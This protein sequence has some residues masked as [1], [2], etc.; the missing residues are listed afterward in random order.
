[1]KPSDFLRTILPTDG[2]YALVGIK[3]KK[4]QQVLVD[5]ITA[6]GPIIRASL[7]N[8]EDVYFGCASYVNPDS[9]KKSN[10]YYVKSFWI[11]LDCGEGTAYATQQD[12]FD[13]LRALCKSASMPK[14][15]VVNSGRGLHVYWP[16]ETAI[17]APLWGTYATRLVEMC[18]AH[19][20]AIKDPGCSTDAARILR[21]PDTF[22]FKNPDDPLAV[23][24]IC[25]GAV[26]SWDSLSQMI[27]AACGTV[28]INGFH[29][30]P[31]TPAKRRPVDAVTAALMG[32]SVSS[33]KKIAMRS[34]NGTGCAHIA[35]A[36]KDQAGTPEP[37]WRAGL[38]IAEHCEDRDHAI[39]KISKE[40]PEYNYAET[41]AKAAATEGPYKCATIALQCGTGHCMKCE[42]RNKITSPIQLGKSILRA[43]DPIEVISGDGTAS[44]G[45]AV[46]GL[47]EASILPVLPW[48]Y[49]RGKQGGIYAEGVKG[50][51][52]EPGDDVLIYE[53]NLDI[54]RRI[55]D[56]ERGETLVMHLALPKD[57]VQELVIPLADAQSIERMK[58]KLG[59]HGVAA[60]KDQ[61]NRISTYMTKM[62]KHMQSTSAAEP[63][64]TQMGWTGDRDGIVWGR[65]MFTKTGSQYCPPAAKSTTVANM[66]RSSGSLEMWE[67]IA[68][69]YAAPGFELYACCMVMAFG[70]MLNQYT[71]E[72]PVWIH[73]VSSDSGT[74][75]TTL[76]HVMDSIWGDPTTMALTAAD[77]INSVEKRRVVFNSMPIC[78]DEITNYPPEKISQ[79]AYSQSQGREKLRLTSGSQEMVNNDRRNNTYFSTGN[80]FVSDI[81][82]AFKTNSAGE[83]ARLIEI[84]FAPLVELVS[85]DDHFGK[86]K[87][88]YGHA[89]PMFAKW[90]VAHADEL[91]ERVDAVRQKF[92]KDFS[93]VSK[94]RN[95]VGTTAAGFAAITIL[96]QELGLLKAYDIPRLYEF[97]TSHMKTVRA[98][99][100]SQVVSH[101]NVIGDFIN[102]NYNNII[103]PDS[104]AATAAAIGGAT[105]AIYGR[106]TEREARNKLV[107]RWEKTTQQ[108]F[109]TQNE[110]KAYCNKRSHS[111]V[112]L[113]SYYSNDKQFVGVVNKRMGSGTDIVTTPVKAL[114]FHILGGELGEILNDADN[115]ST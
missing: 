88:H 97:W 106:K 18:A 27:Q 114:K 42:H 11:D 55:R 20:L 108:L 2:Y 33:F 62:V 96:Q 67:S 5:D 21:I 92:E 15:W 98:A 112:D 71:Y 111:F 66:M 50:P 103:I 85:S 58:D 26:T 101:E 48:P 105:A 80:R 91:Q 13:A 40:H 6:M 31:P 82:G 17:I 64:R 8:N 45:I 3:N 14:P 60:G 69:R 32:N 76:M 102:E 16:L 51:E 93:S 10:V 61:M 77:T 95:W 44:T 90:L 53:Y 52:G 70:S 79:L 22:N 34:L 35:D 12:G 41:E 46:A 100:A 54:V 19:G 99:T 84:P 107:I 94:E 57:G 38:S 78:Q 23:S 113:I 104:H 37:L 109:I 68:G 7:S 28:G 47:T 81:L 39:H 30:E 63:A 65:T 83:L 75:K 89:G 87:N 49:F 36:I 29:E 73:L 74:G 110:L 43:E 24:I 25:S 72:D 56:P 4:I 86:I 1:M 59:H 9:R 115:P